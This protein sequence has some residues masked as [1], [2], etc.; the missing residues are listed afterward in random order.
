M[1]DN[2]EETM[3]KIVPLIA[4]SALMICTLP[5][6]S[7]GKS[8]VGKWEMND[9]AESGVK[10]GG[11]EFKADGKGSMYMDTTEILHA[12]GKKIQVGDNSRRLILNAHTISK[13]VGTKNTT[14][15]IQTILDIIK[16][17]Q[18]MNLIYR[19]MKASAPHPYNN[20]YPL[21][22]FVSNGDVY[23]YV[24]NYKKELR[25]LAIERIDKITPYDGEIVEQ[26]YDF[27]AILS[28]PFGI[29][30][31][32]KEPYTVKLWIN[33]WEGTYLK[34]K[35]WPDSVKITDNDDGS[36]IFEAETR[37]HY[38]CVT[39]IQ[40][41]IDRI[42]ILEPEWLRQEVMDNIRKAMELNAD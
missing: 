13:S 14:K 42:K 23:V 22:I 34:Q 6:C 38:D 2:K 17:H 12:D 24:L 28:D 21:Q 4:A 26:F 8:I 40:A 7:S 16:K 32:E 27:R 37:T 39:W 20:L 10:V 11:I 30:L 5:S 3:R 1:N 25:M 19:R 35:E 33:N 29:I 18:W 15:A 31:E 41:R 9:L 36:I